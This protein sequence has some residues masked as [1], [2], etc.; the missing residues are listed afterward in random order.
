MNSCLPMSKTPA[1]GDSQFRNDRKGEERER[2]EGC[3]ERASQ[4]GDCSIHL[5]KLATYRLGGLEREQAGYRQRHDRLRRP[6]GD[7]HESAAVVLEH[8]GT[9]DHV[10]C[11]RS[12]NDQVV[13]VVRDR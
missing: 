5:F 6:S 7:C 1:R 3:R 11:I 2:T 12:G 13:R 9:N 4:R 8:A 10:G